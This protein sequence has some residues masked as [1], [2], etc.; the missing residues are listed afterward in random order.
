MDGAALAPVVSAADLVIGAAAGKGDKHHYI[1]VFYSK[2]WAGR[3]GRVCEYS[4]PFDVVKPRRVHPDGTGYVRGLY[5]VPRNDPRVS[6]FI[7]REFFKVTDNGAARVLQMFKRRGEIAWTSD[8]RSAWS[9]FI[10][11]LMIRN[12]EYVGC[13][14]AEVVRFFDPD[15]SNDVNERYRAIKRPEE[16]ETYA[17]Y[18]ALTGHPAGRASAIAMKTVIDSPLMGGHLNKMRWS[19]VS[20]KSATRTFLTSDRPIIMTN[21]LVGPDHHLAMPIG[22]RMLFVAANTEQTEHMIRSWAPGQLMEHVNDRVASQARRYVW[23][24]DDAELRF[25]EDR[26]GRMEPSTPLDTGVQ[27]L[28]DA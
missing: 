28:A 11:S 25:V 19:I 22:P 24:V 23:G 20:F 15:L 14:A 3:D 2:E 13:L 7:E 26:L 5:T 16:P 17:E 1:P 9:R 12:P 10:V 8:T 4:R 6:E 18:I 21:G 27:A